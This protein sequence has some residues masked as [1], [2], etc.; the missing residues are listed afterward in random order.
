MCCKQAIVRQMPGRIIGRTNDTDGKTGYTL[1][2]QAREQ[3]IRRSKA[4]SN[5]CTNQGL[6]VTAATIYISLLGEVGL[7]QVASHCHHNTRRLIDKLCAIKGV[8]LAFDGPFFHE[9][10]LRIDADISSLVSH[11]QQRGIGAGFSLAKHYPELSDC[12]IVCATETKT[13]ARLEH[14][15]K[16][17]EAVLAEL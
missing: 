15:A 4:T 2:L 9:A 13:E 8:E 6:L 16:Q 12:L 7:K 10:V 17:L 5:I 3:H 11:L 1:T 14:Y